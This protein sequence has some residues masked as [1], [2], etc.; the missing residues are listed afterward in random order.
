MQNACI[1]YN[2]KT[3]TVIA[4]AED[5]SGNHPLRHAGVVLKCAANDSA[6]T[7]SHECH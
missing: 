6:H 3:R 4:E 2:P 1:A 7:H 5:E